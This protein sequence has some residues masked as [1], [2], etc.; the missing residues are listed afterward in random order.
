M[1][2]SKAL[3]EDSQGVFLKVK[4]LPNS[5]KFEVHGTDKWISAVKIRVKSPAVKGKAN[6][7]LVEGLSRIFGTQ[8]KIVSGEKS[9]KR[10]LHGQTVCFP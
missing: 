7:E 1:I 5:K 10:M 6:H 2:T 8:A 3:S 9:N 4:V